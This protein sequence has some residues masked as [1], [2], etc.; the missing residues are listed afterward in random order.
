MLERLPAGCFPGR[1]KRELQSAQLELATSVCTTV[2]HLRSDLIE[3]RV[4]LARAA[5]R[6]DLQVLA[7]GCGPRPHRDAAA[8]PRLD[9]YR[10]IRERYADAIR[11]YD[12]C[13]CHVHV[14]VPDLATAVAVVDHLRPWLPTLVALAANS[15][16]RDGRY[17][18]YAS[19]RIVA[20]SR[21]PG[22]GLPPWCGSAQEYTRQVS[23]LVD[24]GV[25]V[26]DRMTF[27]LA[28]P[29]P[30]YPTVEVRVADT[31]RSADDAILQAVLTR[32]LVR[33][34][35][36]D[37]AAG[38]EGSRIDVQVGAAAVWSAARYGLE[39]TGI[40]VIAE[41]SVP[42]RKLLASLLAAVADDLDEL[43]DR[44]RADALVARILQAGTGA[45]QQRGPG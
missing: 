39:G 5:R 31:G 38:R 42:A 12:A 19:W 18:G 22:A 33:R 45:A 3:G 26:D 36:R 30:R 21:F 7:L 24:L 41:T 1:H 4:L 6:V 35:I 34:A 28:R 40:D 43:G 29:S 10:A 9:R 11:G 32:A 16:F 25:L 13:G 15:P 27:W 23:R 37:L 2:E 8:K 44:G 20:L 17:T 14:G